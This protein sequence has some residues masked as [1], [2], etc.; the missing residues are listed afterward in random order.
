ML[1]PPQNGHFMRKHP[2]FGLHGL[3][4]YIFGKIHTRDSG[5]KGDL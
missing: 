4:A 5:R 2:Q 1:W 3:E